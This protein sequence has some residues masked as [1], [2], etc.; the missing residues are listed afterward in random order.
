MDRKDLPAENRE[1]DE[2]KSQNPQ[3]IAQ[4]GIITRQV[5]DSQRIPDELEFTE[6]WGS[7]ECPDPEKIRFNNNAGFSLE[8]IEASCLATRISVPVPQPDGSVRHK[9]Y[10]TGLD[11]LRVAKENYDHHRVLIEEMRWY[12]GHPE[13][14]PA[15]DLALV[16]YNLC[17]YAQASISPLVKE[18]AAEWYQKYE[19]LYKQLTK[20]P[21]TE[22]APR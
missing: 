16:I 9:K 13:L 5:L 11:P 14:M 15:R 3:K 4:D 7:F 10:Q 18:E 12:A 20:R 1:W 17:C 8:E 19:A 21:Y 2:K 6:E 22:D